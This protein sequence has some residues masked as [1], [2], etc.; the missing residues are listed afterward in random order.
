MAAPI[1]H[2]GDLERQ[3]GTLFEVLDRK[4]S[5]EPRHCSRLRRMIA[6]PA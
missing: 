2:S 4:R 5:P 6:K 1:I 3:S